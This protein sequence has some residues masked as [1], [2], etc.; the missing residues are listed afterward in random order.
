MRLITYEGSWSLKLVEYEENDLPQYAVLSHTWGADGE[1]VTFKDFTEGDIEGKA[2]YR[3]LVF[4]SKQAARDGIQHFW[5]DTCCIDKSSSAELNEAINSM[6]H[7]YRRA[8]K[9]YVYLCDVPR[10]EHSTCISQSLAGWEAAFRRSR[11]F[12]RGWTL[13]ELIAPELVEFFAQDGSYLGSKITLEQPIHE[14]TGIGSEVLRGGPLADVE[15][16]ERLSWAR[17]RETKRP[18][19]KAYSLCGMFNIRMS[20]FY[21][22]GRDEAFNRLRRKIGKSLKRMTNAIPIFI[23]DTDHAVS[24]S[25]RIA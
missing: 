8:S 13:Q 3:K 9:C 20:L 16:E 21:G 19:D 2:G 23:C 24:S 6:F 14:I 5:I 4:C 15:V 7:W 22:E 12:T 11:W 17:H 25:S 10:P 18:E 1:E